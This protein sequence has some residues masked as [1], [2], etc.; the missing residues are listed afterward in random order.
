MAALTAGRAINAFN[1]RAGRAVGA[2]DLRPGAASRCH[3]RTAKTDSRCRRRVARTGGLCLRP[4]APGRV[5]GALNGSLDGQAAGVDKR[6]ASAALRTAR[7]PAAA[8]R[9]ATGPRRG[10]PRCGTTLG[11]NARGN[12]IG[13]NQDS[14]GALGR[15]GA[16]SLGGGRERERA[17]ARTGARRYC[18]LCRCRTEWRHSG[19]GEGTRSRQC[20]GSS[21]S[22]RWRFGVRATRVMKLYP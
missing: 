14:L 4:A 20:F 18:V 17:V 2:I 6:T 10:L 21:C 16:G 22:A 15:E 11:R 1:P 9:T 12:K 8:K 3:Q 7:A 5:V 19:T 13:G